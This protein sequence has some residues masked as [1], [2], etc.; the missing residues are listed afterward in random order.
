M[1]SFIKIKI[2]YDDVIEI[3]D[4]YDSDGNRWYE[5]DYLAQDTVFFDELNDSYYNTQ[6]NDGSTEAPRIL[7]MKKISKRFRIRCYYS[8]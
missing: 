8:L 2:P 6:Y 7:K 5:V 4:V 1:V 3:I